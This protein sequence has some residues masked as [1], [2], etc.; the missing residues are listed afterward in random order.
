M[1]LSRATSVISFFGAL[2]IGI[3]SAWFVG[4]PLS[5]AGDELPV[6][7]AELPAPRTVVYT[8]SVRAQSLL[9]RWKGSWKYW[10][11]SELSTTIDIDRVYGNTFYGTLSQNG[12][13]V[14]FEGTFDADARTVD[15]SEIKVIKLGQYSRWLLG[16]YRGS[17]SDDGR[18]LSGSGKDSWDGYDWDFT[19]MREATPLVRR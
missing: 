4:I 8:P 1:Y 6:K 13:E 3:A 14:E 7:C 11:N 9:G 18:I 2:V 10:R 16:T 5:P 15:F 17:L 19:K 12:A